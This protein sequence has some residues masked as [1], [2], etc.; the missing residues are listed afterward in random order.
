MAH[1]ARHTFS[2]EDYVQLEE[3]SA[4]KHE[5]LDGVVY[6]MAGGSPAHAGIAG[7]AIRLLGNALEGRRC[8]VFTSDLRVRVELT[9]LTTY[10]DASV[11][12]GELRLD[13]LD[14]KGHTVLNPTVIVEVLSPTTEDYDRGEKLAH[15][16]RVTSL[17]EIVLVAHDE[18]RVDIW[19]RQDGRW[20]QVTCKMGEVL[21]LTSLQ[22]SFPVAEL[23]RDPLSR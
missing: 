9:G 13:P 16:K 21:E 2:F 14:A 20:S 23:Y 12:C 19:R 5:F 4:I 22:V 8:R 15:F 7:N 11:V 6:A 10:P 1:L 3:G 18:Q 17:Q